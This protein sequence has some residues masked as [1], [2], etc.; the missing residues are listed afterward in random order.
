[1]T[2]ATRAVPKPRLALRLAFAGTQALHTVEAT[3]REA[4]AQRLDEVWQCIAARLLQLVPLQ[5]DPARAAEAQPGAPRISAFYAAEPP[6]L[7]LVTGLCEGADALAMQ[8]FQHLQPTAPLQRQLAAVLPTQVAAYRALRKDDFRATFDQLLAACEYVLTLDGI[9]EKP[10][11]PEPHTDTQKQRLDQAKRRRGRA[12]RAQAAVLLRQADVLVAVPDLDKEGGAGGT[13]ETVQQALNFGLPVVLIDSRDG[14][15]RLL[16]P[17]Q[18]LGQV[19]DEPPAGKM[20]DWQHRLH[21]W[22]TSIVADPQ[23]EQHR[24]AEAEG[25]AEAEEEDD[26]AAF[27]DKLLREYFD[28]EAPLRYERNDKG[29]R[30]RRKRWLERQWSALEQRFDAGIKVQTDP[31]LAAYKSWRT[32]A[33]NLNYH[34]AGAYRGTFLV[35]YRLAA[36]AVFLATLSLLVVIFDGA[37][38][39]LLILGLAKLACVVSIFRNTHAAQHGLWNDRAVDYR[40]IAERLRALYY[41]PHA[42][43]VQP[44]APAAPGYASRAVHQSAADWLVDAMV[45]AVSPAEALAMP[46][47]AAAAD[48]PKIIALDPV[49]ALKLIRTRWIAE[50]ARYHDN[51]AR[52]MKRLRNWLDNTARRC[53]LWVI[54]IVLIDVLLLLLVL[55]GEQHGLPEAVHDILHVLHDKCAPLLVAAAAVLPAVVASLNGVRFQSEC[56]RLAERSA[57]MRTQLEGRSER[58]EKGELIVIPEGSLLAEADALRA[59]IQAAQQE[60]EGDPGAWAHEVLLFAEKTADCFARDVAEWSVLYAKEVPEP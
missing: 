31:A 46:Q 33:A 23:T 51:N 55:A 8:R 6:L 52:R 56:Q 43:S 16:A 42:G 22:V 28:D 29:E 27:G 41:L 2:S 11:F 37:A 45:R 19:L 21:N 60:P 10:S 13:L 30:A 24:A 7:R 48:G 32:R 12:Y 4:V 17:G 58:N 18:V 54:G 9:L 57:V 35:N 50:Q 20:E 38:L 14:A 49:A 25:D 3:S 5:P 34:Y 1:M 59:R 44:P 39:L 53:N 47:A 40:Y 36:S 15:L 26:A